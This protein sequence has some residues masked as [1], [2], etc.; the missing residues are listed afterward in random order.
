MPLTLIADTLVTLYPIP[1]FT[2]PTPLP[3]TKGALSFALYTHVEHEPIPQSPKIGETS[4]AKTRT[5]P[6][7][8]TS[9]AV[10]C[11]RKIVWYTWKDGE[12]QEVKVRD[13]HSR[14][15]RPAEKY[16]R[17]IHCRNHHEK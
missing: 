12:P 4:S 6:V 15:M 11:R 7:V 5:V 9:F 13:L 17:K 3:K 8:V 1:G 2:P 16:H 14:I 10:G